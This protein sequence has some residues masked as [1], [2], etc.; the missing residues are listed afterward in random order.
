M[1]AAAYTQFKKLA[2][3]SDTAVQ[4][5]AMTAHMPDCPLMK[6]MMAKKHTE[7][8]GGK[9]D[10]CA[11]EGCFLK[12]FH[13]SDVSIQQTLSRGVSYGYKMRDF[14][15]PASLAS[16]PPTPPPQA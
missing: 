16:A 14:A 9:T 4:T 6:E 1:P 2:K 15:A 3:P 12:C 5:T 11:A 8:E 13:S 7:H 10:G